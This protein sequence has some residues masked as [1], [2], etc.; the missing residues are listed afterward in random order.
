MKSCRGCFC[1]DC[2][3][4]KCP[5]M[6]VHQVKYLFLGSFYLLFCIFT[7][8]PLKYFSQTRSIKSYHKMHGKKR[9][10]IKRD[11]AFFSTQCFFHFFLKLTRRCCDFFL[12]SLIAT[13]N[14]ERPL[15][16]QY[17]A[18][19]KTLIW[20]KTVPSLDQ[21]PIAASHGR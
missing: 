4:V 19:A 16:G 10:G 8:S 17:K 1:F 20:T 18:R 7:C 3:R 14:A 21:R 6:W 5:L 2:F 11:S 12:Q 15:N 9:K 13:M